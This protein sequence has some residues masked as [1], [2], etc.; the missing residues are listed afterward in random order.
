MIS[1][2]RLLLWFPAVLGMPGRRCEC[3]GVSDSCTWSEMFWAREV[4]TPSKDLPGFTITDR[5]PNTWLGSNKPWYDA[6]SQQV[7]YTFR[8]GDST[9][10]F[11]A[12]PTFFRGIVQF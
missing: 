7:R 12:M 8:Q 10:F 9:T 4:F 11:W 2:L 1:L 5:D 6:A 3:S